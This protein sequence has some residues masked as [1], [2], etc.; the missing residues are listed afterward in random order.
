MHEHMRLGFSAWGET[1]VQLAQVIET[2]VDRFMIE[3]GSGSRL[4]LWEFH[5][6]FEMQTETLVD[7][8]A[9]ESSIRS[10]SEAIHSESDY[11][12]KYFHKS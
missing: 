10:K 5:W 4:G 7:T 8:K 2:A 3:K 9:F 6:N 12:F 1:K 11:S